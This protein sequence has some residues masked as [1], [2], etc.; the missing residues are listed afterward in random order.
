MNKNLA[1]QELIPTC[2]ECTSKDECESYKKYIVFKKEES[3]MKTD[4]KNKELMGGKNNMR[5]F[6]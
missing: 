5:K 1:F 2:C 3:I 4:K 6:F